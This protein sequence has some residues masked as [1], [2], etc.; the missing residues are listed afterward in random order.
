MSKVCISAYKDYNETVF[1]ESKVA[2]NEFAKIISLFIYSRNLK[3]I[4]TDTQI[5][6]CK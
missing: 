3:L 6:F 1:T 4:L 2:L 5:D